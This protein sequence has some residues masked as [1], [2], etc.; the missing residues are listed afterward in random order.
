MRWVVLGT[1]ARTRTNMHTCVT[2]F[3]EQMSERYDYYQVLGV[4]RSATADELKKAYKKQALLWH[5]DRHS[6]ATEVN[7]SA[8]CVGLIELKICE[9]SRECQFF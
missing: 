6:N 9:C 3:I 4:T 2:E 7:W 8:W 5:P 1:H